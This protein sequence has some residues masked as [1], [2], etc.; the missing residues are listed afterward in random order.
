MNSN[1][2]KIDALVRGYYGSRLG[3]FVPSDKSNELDWDYVH[4]AFIKNK[5]VL[6]MG[7]CYPNDAIEFGKYAKKWISIDFCPEVIAA[8]K[9]LDLGRYSQIHFLEMDMRKLEYNN[10]EFD[11]VLDM[12]AGDHLSWEDFTICVQETYR[13]LKL[14]GS[15]VCVYANLNDYPN[16]ETFGGDFGYWRCAYPK[17]IEDLMIYAG[18]SIT[19]HDPQYGR[20]AILVEK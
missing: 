6:D 9:K 7:C 16:E 17:D 13:V 18:F 19:R 4:S 14:G 1:S 20:S 11:V 5:T 12:S 8:C 10:E 2:E 15:F 3:S